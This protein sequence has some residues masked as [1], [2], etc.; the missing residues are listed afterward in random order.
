MAEDLWPDF[1][2]GEA[3][4]TPRVVIQEAGEGL[5]K[6]TDGLI[7]FYSA[8]PVIKEKRVAAPFNLYVPALSYHFPFLRAEFDIASFY[9]VKVTA[10]KLQEVTAKNEKE[11]IAA[12]AEIFRAPSTVETVQGLMSLVKSEPK[13][14]KVELLKL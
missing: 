13:P 6:K 10:S 4:R 3:P 8:T 9:P 12:L 2:V 1:K 11:L 14:A 7:R 5:E